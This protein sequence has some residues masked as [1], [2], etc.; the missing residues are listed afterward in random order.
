MVGVQKISPNLC[1]ISCIQRILK[2]NC[3]A[4]TVLSSALIF[5][6]GF[7]I[8]ICSAGHIKEAKTVTLHPKYPAVGLTV[9]TLHLTVVLNGTQTF[10]VKIKGNVHTATQTL[11]VEGLTTTRYRTFVLYFPKCYPFQPLVVTS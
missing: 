2:W 9:I 7:Y 3:L 1:I 5:R 4:F 8:D 6:V 10:T 11:S